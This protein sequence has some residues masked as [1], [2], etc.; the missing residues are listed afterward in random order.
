MPGFRHPKA[1]LCR[2]I[3]IV[4]LAVMSIVSFSPELMDMSSSIVYGG[5]AL[6]TANHTEQKIDQF[7][8]QDFLESH[9]VDSTNARWIQDYVN[10]HNE[11][12]QLYRDTDLLV[13]PHGPPVVIVYFDEKSEGISGR[14]QSIGPL[15]K[16]CH[17]QHRILLLQFYNPLP[18]ETFL[19]PTLFNWTVP[20]HNTTV[21]QDHLES[22]YPSLTIQEESSTARVVRLYKKDLKKQLPKLHNVPYRVMWHLYF[23]PSQLLQETLDTTYQQLG[24]RPGHYHAIHC[25]ILHPAH[26]KRFKKNLADKE[27]FQDWESHKVD[28]M[29]TAIRAIQCSNWLTSTT[30]TTTKESNGNQT[31]LPTYFFSD[32]HDLV[33]SVLKN[34]NSACLII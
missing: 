6:S 32:S 28:A 25:R 8:I 19:A 23:Q 22:T 30:I 33:Q 10:W 26:E 31:L 11:Q 4:A 34:E 17:E 27:G 2:I 16:F 5:V 15:L 20:Y 21:H 3:G 7:L 12:R 1:K 14:F 18:L 29:E 13:H 24:I 9:H